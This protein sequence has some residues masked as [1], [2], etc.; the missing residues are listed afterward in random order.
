MNASKETKPIGMRRGKQ[1]Y[2][3]KMKFVFVQH[4]EKMTGHEF[5]PEFLEKLT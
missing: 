1:I 3:D 4:N 2:I 5:V